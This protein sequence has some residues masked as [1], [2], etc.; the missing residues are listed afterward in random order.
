MKKDKHGNL[1][2]HSAWPKHIREHIVGEPEYVGKVDENDTNL[3]NVFLMNCAASVEDCALS[4]TRG[5]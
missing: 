4:R 1:I 2:D 5:R 3:K